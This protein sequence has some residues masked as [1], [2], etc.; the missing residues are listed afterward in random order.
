M[1]TSAELLLFPFDN[2]PVLVELIYFHT[3]DS[4]KVADYLLCIKPGGDPPIRKCSLF[5]PLSSYAYLSY[6]IE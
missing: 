3:L 4:H 1:I 5:H 2:L 6:R